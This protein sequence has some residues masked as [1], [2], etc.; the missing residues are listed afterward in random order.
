MII[1]GIVLAL[2]LVTVFGVLPLVSKMVLYNQKGKHSWGAL[3]PIYSDI[4]LF[5]IAG[6]SPWLILLYLVPIASTIIRIISKVKFIKAYGKSTAFAILALFFPVIF[7]P[8][9]AFP[10][11]MKEKQ[12]S[13]VRKVNKVLYAILT[14]F[15]G[16]I[17]I[18]K[19]YAHKIKSGIVSLVF[20]WTLIPAI[21]SMVEFIEILS[22]EKDK[23]GKVFVTTLRK[24]NTMFKASAAIFTLFVIFVT[25]PW[26]SLFT[27]FTGFTDF[28]TSLAKVKI[29][30]NLIGAPVTMDTMGSSTGV[31][32]VIGSWDIMDLSILLILLSVV[33]V[34]FNKIKL[35]E[36]IPN[37][38]SGIKKVLPVAVVTILVSLVL[39]IL[40]TSGVNLT[41][42]N[43]IISI[44]SN[45]FNIVTTALASIVGSV[46]TS[47]FYYYLST[48]SMPFKTAA[49][50]NDLYGVTAL[51]VSSMY[52]LTMI[53]APTSIALIIG[54]YLMDISYCKWL[55]Y[56]WK[57]L[58]ALFIVVI[59]A[60]LIVYSII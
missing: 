31:I 38:T 21:L 10:V 37:I 30:G 42:V 33:I 50:S 3:I 7:Y 58:L 43:K 29:F 51:I 13:D 46:T 53:F 2:I 59:V 35:D 23:D 17:G 28:N 9:T 34:I 27:K 11:S 56:I 55:K 57:V 54:L 1:V 25:I 49:V 36:F 40:V 32:P 41:L 26:E 47:D 16:W 8:M 12:S 20:C 6:L 39:V 15:F 60:V 14:L 18:N 48:L 24:S 22:E 45:K 4:L 5:K 19:F 44:A 52:Y